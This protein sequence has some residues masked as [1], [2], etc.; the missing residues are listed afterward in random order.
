M[1]PLF[2]TIRI[3]GGRPRHLRYHNARMNRSRRALYG[4]A[5]ELDLGA[6]VLVPDGAGA[7][8]L[9]CRVTY[10]ESIG[11]VTFAPYEPRP[12][13]SL[14][15]VDGGG[16]DYAHK[17]IDRSGIERLLSAADADDVLIVRNGLVTDASAANAAFFDGTR[18]L[19][20]STPLLP[21][22]TR[23]RLL[24]LGLV[25]ARDIRVADIAGFGAAA[26]MNAMIGF[27][28]THP[29]PVSAIRGA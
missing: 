2:E 9:R 13:R 18:W 10:G 29:V 21:G 19:T 12:V 25:V 17:Y 20:P 22:T 14:E 11:E 7:G 8:P 23:A 5:E 6:A 28:T 27:D 1:Y 16:L 26:L 3:E 4:P 15:L 24:E